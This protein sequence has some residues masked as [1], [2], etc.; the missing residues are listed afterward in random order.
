[1]SK[2]TDFNGNV[3]RTTATFARSPARR[4]WL[5]TMRCKAV[6]STSRCNRQVPEGGWFPISLAIVV[7]SMC[8]LWH[9]GTC[10]KM[11]YIN[12]R[13]FQLASLLGPASVS[14]NAGT[15]KYLLQPALLQP[16]QL[17]ACPRSVSPPPTLAPPL[18]CDLPAVVYP[19][20]GCSVHNV[21][22]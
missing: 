4:I 17:Q 12:E 13:A 6:V 11:R 8:L 3:R 16:A 2:L 7:L 5:E 22:R 14:G 15:G 9:W 18:S 1:M 20:A 21:C 19:A 10:R